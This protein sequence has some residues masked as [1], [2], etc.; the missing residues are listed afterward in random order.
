MN[1]DSQQLE[2]DIGLPFEDR[3]EILFQEIELAVRW[4]RPSILFAI[5]KS[6]LIREEVNTI[7]SEKLNNIGQKTHSIKTNY[8]DQFNFLSEISQLPDL[9]QT[10]LFIDGF[11]WECG[12][13]GARVFK[14]F[15]EHREYFID[16]NIRAIFWLYE[17]EVSEFATNATECWILRHRM[18][19]FVDVPQQAQ[20]LIQ[21]LESH[22]QSTDNFPD[23]EKSSDCS[24]EEI[25]PLKN[26]EKENTSHANAL[27][28]LG[29]LFWRKGNTQRALKYLRTSADIS[30]SLANHSLQAQCQ[31]ALA[32]V[33]TELGNIDDAV[34]AYQRAI[35]L[36]PESEFLWNNLGKLLAK[37]ERNEEAIHAYKKALSFS[38]Q[39]FLSWDGVGHIY[40]KFGIYQN[41]ISAFEKALEIAPYYEFSWAGIG[42]AYL[43]S[44]LLEKAKGSLCKAVEINAHLIDAWINLGKCFAQQQ[45]DH[46]AINVFHRAIEFNP[47]NTEIWVELGRLHLLRQNYAESISAFQKVISLQPQSGEAYLSLAYAQ[48]QTGDYETSALT[49]ENCIPL[50]EDNETR[51]ALWSR[52]GD[53]YL[54]LKDYEKAIAAYKQSDQLLKDLQIF[55]DKNE[56][57]INVVHD[58]HPNNDQELKHEDSDIERG[59]KMIEANHIF[60]LKTAAEWNEH[61]NTHLKAGAYNDAIV[62]YTKAIE[63]APDACWP[64]IQNL[65]YVHFQKGKA[66]GKLSIGKVEDPDIWEG[67]DESDSVSRI[68]YDAIP[69]PEQSDVNEEPRLEKS[70][71][72]NPLSQPQVSINTG[73]M[74]SNI[75]ENSNCC[76][77]HN[78]KTALEPEDAVSIT[79]KGNGNSKEEFPQK[80]ENKVNAPSENSIT[81]QVVEKVPQNSFDWNELGNLYTSSQ[82]FA[83][84]IEAYKKAIEMDPKYGQPYC[85]LGFTYYR[86]GKYE[87]AIL[88][89]KKS[90]DLLDTPEDKAVSWNRVGD[91]YR[92]LG[93]YGNALAAYQKASEMRPAVSPV[94]ARAR[95]ILLENFVVG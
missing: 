24:T 40:N 28:G 18:V 62:A 32:L 21:S 31:N 26:S 50:F 8:I 15:N 75:L 1:N 6:D 84:S 14:E 89:Y 77:N 73:K 39:D 53:T 20:G 23:D 44:G 70:N 91:A 65:A 12:T 78:N 42:R 74:N 76:S 93:D 5:Y 59:D 60:D 57:L 79:M 47:Q 9:S 48:F 71:I 88:L 27:L 35:S 30:K 33:Q 13:E 37:N 34:S 3:I 2:N 87:D 54:H 25:I 68:G 67:E 43:E 38:P 10:V 63:L 29:M 94:M 36:S 90:L 86:L 69:I 4:D 7:L 95:A 92:R 83:N 51:S 19:E 81:P 64:Y 58:T 80:I 85:N 41:A 61:G 72:N 49:Y 66:R 45:R 46:D 55:S 82:K 56:D 11:N 22:A 16:N 52:L 17:K